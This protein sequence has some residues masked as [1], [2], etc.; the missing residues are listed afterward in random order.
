MFTEPWVDQQSAEG[1]RMLE[2]DS[3]PKLKDLTFLKNQLECLQQRVED[4]VSSD[5]LSAALHGPQH[6]SGAEQSQ[7]WK[8]GSILLPLPR[9]SPLCTSGVGTAAAAGCRS[10]LCIRWLSG[11]CERPSWAPVSSLSLHWDF[12]SSSHIAS[13]L[14][15]HRCT[16]S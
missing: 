12:C 2:K 4:E 1:E 5:D 8:H 7:D 3:L 13:S 16:L 14:A 6:L 11:T 9:A 10:L 15:C